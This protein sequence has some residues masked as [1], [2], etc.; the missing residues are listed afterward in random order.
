MVEKK[1]RN[2]LANLKDDILSEKPFDGEDKDLTV[3]QVLLHVV[4]H[5]TDHRSQ[6]LRIL[7]DMGG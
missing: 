3:W 2:Y 6:M 7:H 5:G 1:M 4:S